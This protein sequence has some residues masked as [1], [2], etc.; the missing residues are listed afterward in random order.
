MWYAI[1]CLHTCNYCVQGEYLG[2]FLCAYYYRSEVVDLE[3]LTGKKTV[4]LDGNRYR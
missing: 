3:L 1:I 4:I 2:S